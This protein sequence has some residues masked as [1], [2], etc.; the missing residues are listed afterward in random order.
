MA[1]PF[2]GQIEAFAFNFPPNG[3]AL[4]N[5]A[6]LPINQNTALFS[7]LG[8]QFGGDGRVTFALPDLRGRIAN[9][10]GQ[11]P[12]LAPYVMGQQFG[13]ELHTVTGGEMP[14]AHNHAV[15]AQI[16]GT[17]GGGNVPGAGLLA[18]AYSARD[19][20]TVNIYAGASGPLSAMTTLNPM[21]GQAHENRMPYNV[22]NYCIC[23]RGI[24][25]SRN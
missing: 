24:F 3:W 18:S 14:A 22:L 12:G 10:D 9:G 7:L 21:G 23:L 19:S 13:E 2:I 4:C 15:N 11:G 5:G 20:S 1:N 6:L 8:T 16:N 25:P 17:T